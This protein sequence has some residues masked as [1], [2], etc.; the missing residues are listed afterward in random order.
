MFCKSSSEVTMDSVPIVQEFL[1]VFPKNSP[2][3][4][5]NREFE[6]GIELLPNSTP[7]S[8]L[9]YKMTLAELKEL[10]TQLQYHIDKGFI[11][12]SVSL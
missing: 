3:L 7:I 12:P 1:D 5:P 2:D 6:F 8:I 10:K 4:P 11:Q 9:P